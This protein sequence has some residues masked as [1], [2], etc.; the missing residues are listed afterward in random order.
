MTTEVKWRRGCFYDLRREPG[1]IAALEN[2]GRHIV[3]RANATL[4]EGAGY[5]MSSRQ[6]AKK[7]KGRWRVTVYTA[8][9]HAKRS[10]AKHNTL[11]KLM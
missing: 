4:K 9:T 8:S 3:N 5:R 6:G 10:N 2:H 11:I 7:P 1:V